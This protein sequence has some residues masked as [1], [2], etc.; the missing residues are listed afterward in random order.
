M[1][2][3][4]ADDQLVVCTKNGG[5]TTTTTCALGCASTEA[6]CLGFLP[7]NGLGPALAES[8]NEVDTILPTGTRIDTDLGVIQDAN[9]AT[10]TVKTG[11]VTQVGGPDIRV[12]EARSFAIE[13]VTVFGS[14]ALAFVTI[15]A[16]SLT[17]R[18]QARAH[19]AT[20][21]PGSQVSGVCAGTDVQ[22]FVNGCP[23]GTG[24]IGGGGGGNAQEGG[25]GGATSFNGGMAITAYS[26]LVGG[27]VGGSQHNVSGS[28]VLAHGGGGG[29]GLQFVSSTRIV[30]SNHGF[31][32]LGAGGGQSTAG[33][34][35]G[36][37]LILEAP[38]VSIFGSSAGVV[39]NGGAGGGCG[40][41]GQDATADTSQAMGIFCNSYFPGNGGTGA[42]AP[43]RG[44]ISAV[45]C[46]SPATCPIAY[47]GGGGSV[48]RMRIVTKDGTFTT[49]GNPVFSVQ[50]ATASLT[51]R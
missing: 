51:P 16:I 2:L 6:R 41:N 18:L 28:L 34:G 23:D 21:G 44:C 17:G 27:C 22:Q 4:C 15:G 45:D 39:A 8:Q 26:P 24:E 35:S 9:G 37:T 36:G 31:V 33:G 13:D 40:A 20:G 1:P 7:S 25:R 14:R 46:I 48:G 3:S 11:I 10:I 50:I 47:G 12:F 32:D 49:S 19:G 29:G 30:F 42:L 38:E 5:S 43:G